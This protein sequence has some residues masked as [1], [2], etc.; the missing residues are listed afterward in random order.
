MFFSSCKKNTNS[1]IYNHNDYKN[2]INSP[3]IQ[4]DKVWN[5]YCITCHKKETDYI[6]IDQI[7]YWEKAAKKNIDTLFNHVYYGFEGKYG[8]MP[9]RGSCYEC[10]K[11]EIKNSIYHL[12]YL[13]DNYSKK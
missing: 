4:Y 1:E 12:F 6:G 2:F 10:S 8:V 11:I 3:N 13:S 9:K 7:E 5:T